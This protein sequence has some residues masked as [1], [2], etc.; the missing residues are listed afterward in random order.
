MESKEVFKFF[1]ERKYAGE[2]FNWTSN[3]YTNIMDLL[4]ID[5]K[6]TT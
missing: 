5:A 4:K 3:F 1:T 2:G 6:Q